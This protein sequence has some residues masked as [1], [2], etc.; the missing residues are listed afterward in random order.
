MAGTLLCEFKF[1][2]FVLLFVSMNGVV[3]NSDFY[4]IQKKYDAREQQFL[5]A[6]SIVSKMQKDK[7]QERVTKMATLKPTMKVISHF[8]KAYQN[9]VNTV[10][11][12]NANGYTKSAPS[13]IIIKEAKPSK[14][15]GI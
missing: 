8:P 10:R 12:Q 14:L 15:N 7:P 5:R 1:N 3:N 11:K 13:N 6:R 4:V 9:P 2:L